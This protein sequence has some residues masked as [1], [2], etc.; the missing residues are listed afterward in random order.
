MDTICRICLVPIPTEHAPFH[1]INDTLETKVLDFFSEIDLSI[2]PNPVLCEICK[3]MI[4]EIYEFKKMFVENENNLK[5][6]ITLKSQP[7]RNISSFV[8]EE[9]FV[10]TIK[11]EIVDDFDDYVRIEESI[12]ENV[13]YYCYECDYNTN[14]RQ[15]LTRHI[16]THRFQCEKC[17][18]VTCGKSLLTAHN[19]VCPNIVKTEMDAS[20][21]NIFYYRFQQS[22]SI[23]PLQCK[24]SKVSSQKR[25]SNSFQCDGCGY[26]TE[27][28]TDLEHHMLQ[29]DGE[30][31]NKYD[32]NII[33]CEK[34]NY[35]TSNKHNL[36]CHV[37]RMH[38]GRLK[39][40]C[41]LCNYATVDKRQ[42]ISH[43]S[44]HTEEKPF[45]CKL[46]NYSCNHTK[47][48]KAHM[49]KH[50]GKW[51]FECDKCDYKTFTKYKMKNHIKRHTKEKPF[52]C[53]L[54]NYC[55][56]HVHD[57]KAHLYKHSGDWPFVCN[58]CDYK[59]HS[60]TVFAKH[61]AASGGLCRKKIVL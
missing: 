3:R 37:Y 21:E 15:N 45:K 13:I 11:E 61:E 55:S 8:K 19:Q 46:C 4:E 57:L 43:I 22:P 2:I 48:L 39:Q 32:S 10:N 28:K 29:H 25:L 59:T 14:D 56:N 60:K 12:D 34:C 44:T 47:T 38:G 26:C 30:E 31:R 42:L 41:K 40:K 5:N 33:K 27:S 23:E 20:P 54:C 35:S 50:S 17:S 16:F 9:T 52:K 6:Q 36:N 49:C 7:A 18:Y 58:T 53:D 24:K 51:P 1:C